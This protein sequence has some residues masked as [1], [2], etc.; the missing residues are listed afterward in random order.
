MAEPNDDPFA[1]YA[2][3]ASGG[4]DDPS[5]PFAK[6]APKPVSKPGVLESVGRGA[7]ESALFG[8]DDK[9]GMDKE[10]RELSRKTN[11][12][13]HFFGELVG[14]AAPMAAAMLLPTGV[15]QAAAGARGAN[16]ATKAAGLVRS[17]FVPGEIGTLGQAAGQGA[18]LGIVG[19]ALS[20]S[21]H[22]EVKPEDSYLDAAK[23]RLTGAV[24][25]AG[26]GAMAGA[27]L[28]AAGYGLYRAAQ[29]IG[30]KLASARAETEPGVRGAIVKATQK[31]EEDRIAP[32]DIINGIVGEFPSASDVAKGGMGRR[33]WGSAA[34]RQPWTREEIEQVVAM[35]A[36]DQKP[37][38][39]SAAMK[40]HNNGVGPGEDAIG[41]IL[42]ELEQRHLGPLNIVDRA[43]MVRPGSGKNTQMS[44]RAVAATPGEAAA[45]ASEGL[46]QRQL[47][48]QER[49]G[50][51]L[52]RQ[53][54]SPD[55]EA[56][57][58]K[59]TEALREAGS[60]AY[61]LA[62][63]QEAPFNL[64]PIL[65][66]WIKKYGGKGGPIPS[67][68]EKNIADF[69]GKAKAPPTTLEDFKLARQGLTDAIDREVIQ[70]ASGAKL[71]NLGGRL[72]D[73]KKELTDAVAKTNPAWEE[74]NLLWRDGKAATDA[75]EAGAKMTT[76]LGS[77]SR[78]HLSEFTAAQAAEKKAGEQVLAAR[79]AI[80]GPNKR[81][82]P[83][84]VEVAAATPAQQRQLALAQAKLEAAQTKQRLFKVGLARA[85][86][87]TFANQGET[88]DV[89]RRLLTPG[90]QKILRQVMGEDADQL[91]AVLRAEQAMARTYQSMATGSQTTPLAEHIKE[92]NYAPNLEASMMNPLTWL[93]PGMRYVQEY[94]ARGINNPRN[95]ELMKLYTGTD[96]LKQLQALRDMQTLHVTRSNAG[97]RAGKPIVGASGPASDALLGDLY[98]SEYIPAAQKTRQ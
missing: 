55:L 5:D 76:R 28:G 57:A 22:A 70:T 29:G 34:N 48:T 87:D 32:Q 63:A 61:A 86:S 78:E 52:A 39:I 82:A 89:T 91:F 37:A 74:A 66:D 46:L 97:N 71:S 54:E 1:K 56:A 15:G 96:P 77:S 3:A 94:M 20:G 31:L 17:A 49:I 40:S 72:S 2:P 90:A 62:E 45:E 42:S 11:P 84:D 30:T 36:Q 38:A 93:G 27:P 83:T 50:Q 19:G 81:R 25:G 43:S 92:H 67:G 41:T 18:K 26:V 8:Y 13:A 9:L 4:A 65:D 7:V 88:A 98:G 6:Y 53:L 60:R 24:K 47:G 58:A 33:F 35:A 21:G 59:H 75:M 12:W 95:A 51:V 80:L 10:R 69:L 73:L 44:M 64:V 85:I 14:G 16:L 23:E 68:I 79:Q